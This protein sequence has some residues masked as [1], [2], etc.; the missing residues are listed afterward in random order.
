MTAGDHMGGGGAGPRGGAGPGG[1][2][3][4]PGSDAGEQLER[5]DLVAL[6]YGEL[7]D[8]AAVRAR[9][10]IEDDPALTEHMAALSRV[11]DLFGEL[12][13][14]EPPSRLSAQLLAQAAAAAPARRHSE[15]AERGQGLWARIVGW[16]EPILRHPSLAAAASLVLIAGVAGALYLRKG[17][18]LTRTRSD[19]TLSEPAVPPATEGAPGAAPAAAADA[20]GPAAAASATPVQ[21]GER[22]STGAASSAAE[23]SAKADQVA[24]KQTAPATILREDSRAGGAQGGGA[25]HGRAAAHRRGRHRVL[26]ATD[27]GGGAGGVV[28]GAASQVRTGTVYG[29]SSQELVPRVPPKSAAAPAQNA[30]P[31]P[32]AASAPAPSTGDEDRSATNQAGRDAPPEPAEGKVGAADDGDAGGV[33]A[34]YQQ[35]LVAAGHKDCARVRSLGM[36][37]GRRDR[38][39][40]DK[41][42]AK[43]RRLRPCLATA[44]PSSTRK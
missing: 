9:R 29:V 11:R 18:E 21:Q 41:V 14:E 38:A 23:E 19:V 17:D 7:D 37:I 1:A 24:K 13:D 8:G 2:D 42:V 10:H 4:R 36:A 43:D 35:A 6:L 31:P 25:G 20:P 28:G 44:S 5:D 30:A 32:A 3:R 16:F 26:K 39:F 22:E 27:K 34:L 33:R 40:Y 12:D 15:A